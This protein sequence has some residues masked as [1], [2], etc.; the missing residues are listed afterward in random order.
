MF[1]LVSNTDE[2]TISV[3]AGVTWA[4]R[5]SFPAKAVNGAWIRSVEGRQ[6]ANLVEQEMVM[7]ETTPTSNAAARSV[8]SIVWTNNITGSPQRLDD[9]AW[10]PLHRPLCSGR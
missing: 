6:S 2:Y 5:Q 10:S 9:V 1:L 7:V 4:A 8:N 3:D